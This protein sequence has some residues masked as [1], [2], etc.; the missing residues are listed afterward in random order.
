MT[1]YELYRKIAHIL[2]AKNSDKLFDYIIH[3]MDDD[4]GFLRTRWCYWDKTLQDGELGDIKT[5]LIALRSP[6]DFENCTEY[7]AHK[8]DF[9]ETLTALKM[10]LFCYDLSDRDAFDN[11]ADWSAQVTY[12]YPIKIHLVSGSFEILPR[13]ETYY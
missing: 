2:S 1:G 3:S 7:Y 8:D 11:A 13:C 12:P 6:F 4:G 10:Q 5:A 9:K